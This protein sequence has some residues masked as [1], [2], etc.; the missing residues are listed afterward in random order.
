[1]RSS[2]TRPQRRM[3]IRSLAAFQTKVPSH[4]IQRWLGHASLQTTAIYGDIMGREERSIAA[5][6]W[7]ID[8]K[9]HLTIHKAVLSTTPHLTRRPSAKGYGAAARPNVWIDTPGRQASPP[10]RRRWRAGGDTCRA[11]DCVGS[12][13]QR[14][15]RHAGA[16]P[17]I[18]RPVANLAISI[19]ALPKGEMGH[20]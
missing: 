11:R 16:V 20:D 13:Y 7:H 4:L 1:M 2:S 15:P 5:R 6:M 14:E 10:S 19:A 18:H 17:A 9:S 3:L 12:P 8:V